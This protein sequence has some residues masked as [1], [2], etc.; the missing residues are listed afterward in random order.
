MPRGFFIETTRARLWYP[1]TASSVSHLDTTSTGQN[2]EIISDLVQ[3]WMC[4]LA[5]SP[6]NRTS[7]SEKPPR[8]FNRWYAYLTSNP[9]K[10][11]VVRFSRLAHQLASQP[12]E[13]GAGSTTGDWI[14]EF[15][16]TPIFKEYHE[17]YRTGDPTLFGYIYTFLNFGKKLKYVDPEMDA[18]AFRGWL[19]V[20]ERLRDLVINDE[21]TK[22]LRIIMRS[23]CP[24]DL[25]TRPFGP[26]FGPGR[27]SEKGIF[28]IVGK[29]N[30]LPYDAK[31]DRAFFRSIFVKQGAAEELGFHASKVIPDPDKWTAATNVSRRFSRLKFVPKD[32]TK[33]RSIC[34]EPNSF[35]FFQQGFENWLVHGMKST[36]ARRFIDIS[37]QS[38]NRELALY[39]SITGL[40]DTID[41][42]SASDSVSVELVKRIFPREILYFLLAT[43]T[44]TVELPTGKITSVYK[45]APMGSALCFP[46]QCLIFTSV[47]ILAAM[48]RASG[49][50]V[51]E[52]LREDAP[53]LRDVPKSVET[54]FRRSPG[55]T[56][57]WSKQHEPAT[58]YGDDICVD[59]R[60]TPYVT[61]LLT[62]LGFEVNISKSF[63]GS[64]CFRE[65]CGGFYYRGFDVTPLYF[66]VNRYS[67]RITPDAVMSMIALANHAGDRRLMHLRRL[68][69]H[70]LLFGDI[71]RKG[72]KPNPVLFT[73][74]HDLPYGVY[75]TKVRNTH[76]KL[77]Y[78]DSY[79][80]DEYRCLMQEKEKWIRPTESE[81]HSV[82]RYLYL[83]WW[84]SH[85]GDVTSDFGHQALRMDP[86][87][88]RLRLGWTP[89]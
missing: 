86:S 52:H 28:G 60:L 17:W 42:S 18:T 75:T 58:V 32:V 62:S 23:L 14:P 40:I 56:T 70:R 26:H 30:N 1:T 6:L 2:S 54:L 38:K 27:V 34:A 4:L 43:R 11:T 61:H 76:L 12:T 5:D 51:G 80:R 46:V 16:D 69:V 47:V 89:A 88:T 19:K 57:P 81:T 22:C 21:T 35:M 50:G 78:N 44:S 41:L 37:D 59:T 55:Y 48:Q 45:F 82:E 39:G 9:I 79:Q 87:G 25:T 13:Y 64:Q 7:K 15:S 3:A 84:E 33:S 65:S 31:L 29:S 10:D 36:I 66:R 83:R 63:M 24:T 73:D 53:W 8:V 49:L 77:R 74:R 72:H 68:M 71:G 67:G 20:E 85:P